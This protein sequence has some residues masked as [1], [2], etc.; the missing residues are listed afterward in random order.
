M[1]RLLFVMTVGILC[2]NCASSTGN[3]NVAVNKTNTTAANTAANKPATPAST[4]ALVADGKSNPELDFTLINKTGYDIKE[5][6]VGPTG[7][8]DWTDEDEI[9]KGRTLA[10]GS[11][12]DIKFSPRETAANWDLMVVWSDGTGTEEWIKLNLTEIEKVTL[13]YDRATDTTSADIE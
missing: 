4:P 5:V 2:L 6:S 8:K 11:S 7:E 13:K 10:N 12:L 3:T 1:R 9:L